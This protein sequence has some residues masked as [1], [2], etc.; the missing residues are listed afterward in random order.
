[1]LSVIYL[2]REARDI[3]PQSGHIE[4][5]LSAATWPLYC[6]PV[7]TPLG[8]SVFLTCLQ[9]CRYNGNL[10]LQKAVF[11]EHLTILVREGVSAVD[12]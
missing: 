9:L 11:E 1:M 8:S 7:E 5:Q 10:V 3:W 12:L 4:L 2:G 6:E